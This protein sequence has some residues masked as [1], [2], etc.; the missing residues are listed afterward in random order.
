M[1]KYHAVISS[2]SIFMLVIMREENMTQV[3]LQMTLVQ[4]MTVNALLEEESPP[5]RATGGTLMIEKERD[6]RRAATTPAFAPI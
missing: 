4:E 5:A 3:M 2:G 1:P 6:A